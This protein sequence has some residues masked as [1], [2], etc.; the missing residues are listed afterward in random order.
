MKK[1]T[2]ILLLLL[3]AFSPLSFAGFRFG[4]GT[5]TITTAG[6]ALAL[7]TTQ[8]VTTLVVCGDIGNTGKMVVGATPVNTSGAQEGII[9]SAGQCASIY[10]YSNRTFDLATIKA[11]TT[12]NGEEVSFFWT[13]E[14]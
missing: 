11:D 10:S 12:V 5:K 3:I 6:T 1:F 2:A 4:D 9:L 13:L 8:D 7:S 14:D